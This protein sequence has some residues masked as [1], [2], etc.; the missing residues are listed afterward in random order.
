MERAIKAHKK[1]PMK[2]KEGKVIP[3]DQKEKVFTMS[4][5]WSFLGEVHK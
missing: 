3:E 1:I 5:V 4:C 2:G